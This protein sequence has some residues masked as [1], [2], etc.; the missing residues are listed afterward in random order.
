MPVC[1]QA[2]FCTCEWGR[3]RWDVDFQHTPGCFSPVKLY[4]PIQHTFNPAHDVL[5]MC[6]TYFQTMPITSALHMC[7]W[8]DLGWIIFTLYR[9]SSTYSSEWDWIRNLSCLHV[10]VRQMGKQH[11]QQPLLEMC[12]FS[13]PTVPATLCILFMQLQTSYTTKT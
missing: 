3:T 8:L 11:R 1:K 10:S 9:T 12:K 7:V 13:L 4:W 6:Q 5:K 2:V